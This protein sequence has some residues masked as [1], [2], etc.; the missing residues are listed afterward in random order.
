MYPVSYVVN[1]WQFIDVVYVAAW[2][3]SYI[4][5]CLLQITQ[6]ISTIM[7]D[8]Y[9]F[10][11]E[12]EFWLVPSVLTGVRPLFWLNVQQKLARNWL[13]SNGNQLKKWLQ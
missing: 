13:T 10:R 5:I 3:Y 6:P 7:Q 4:S 2:G 11:K 1:D 9:K 8:K 12:M